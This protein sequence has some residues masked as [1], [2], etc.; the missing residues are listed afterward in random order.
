MIGHSRFDKV[1]RRVRPSG[2]RANFEAHKALGIREQQRIRLK[3]ASGNGFNISKAK[4]M[5]Y[6]KPGTSLLWVLMARTIFRKDYC[7]F[8]GVLQ[9]IV[10]GKHARLMCL[11]MKQQGRKGTHR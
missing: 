9:G 5:Q 6:P 1:V 11:S 4:H 8:A 3:E 10:Q 2:I 7:C